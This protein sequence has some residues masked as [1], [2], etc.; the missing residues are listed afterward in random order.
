MGQ[1]INKTIMIYVNGNILL[2]MLLHVGGRFL[3]RCEETNSGGP[4]AAAVVPMSGVK[5][6]RRRQKRG[7]GGR[8]RGPRGLTVDLRGNILVADDCSRVCMFSST[9][10]YVRNLLTDEDLVKYPEAVHCSRSGTGL[11]AITEWNPNNMYAVKVF[12]LYE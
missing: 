9:G 1:I 4:L 7:G 6:G 3:F 11:L 5:S 2:T 10:R 8:L 12:T